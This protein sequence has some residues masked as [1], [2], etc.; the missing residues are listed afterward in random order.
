MA[1]FRPAHIH[2]FKHGRIALLPGC[3]AGFLIQSAYD[4]RFGILRQRLKVQNFL[5]FFRQLFFRTGQFPGDFPDTAGQFLPLLFVLFFPAGSRRNFILYGADAA[6]NMFLIHPLRVDLLAQDVNLPLQA[7]FHQY[8]PAHSVTLFLNQ[9]LKPFQ[10][11]AQ[12]IIF[13]LKTFRLRSHSLQIAGYNNFSSFN[14]GKLALKGLRLRQ[15]QVCIVELQTLLQTEIFPGRLRLSGQRANL[16]FQ[17]RQY[18]GNAQQILFLVLQLLLCN[19]L[20][21]LEFDNACGFIE[22][23]APF[24]R[25]PA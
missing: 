23:L 5:L 18:I 6:L 14:F 13:R 1:D 19:Q 11:L 24:L 8:G 17:L 10:F 25:F 21:S 7:L 22:Q 16:L 2:L 9:V 12:L 20:S 15:K 4:F 3:Q